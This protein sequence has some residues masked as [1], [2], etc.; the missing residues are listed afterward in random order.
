MYVGHY[1]IFW[2]LIGKFAVAYFSPASIVASGGI[3]AEPFVARENAST[4]IVY[5]CAAFLWLALFWNLGFHQWPWQ[6]TNPS[7]RLG[8]KFITILLFSTIVYIFL[9]HP[10]VCNLFYPAQDKAG[11]AP[12]WEG[13]A[14]TGSAFFS[15]GLVLCS[16]VWIVFS[17]LLWEG[18]PWKK[19]EKNGEATFQKGIVTFFGTLILGFLLLYILLR[20]FTVIW[21]VPFVGGQ[22]TDGP[23]WRLIHG[24]EVAGFF[25]LAAFIL[26][27][28]FNNFPRLPNLWARA[29]IR[30]LLAIAGG[31]LIYW[32]YFSP[33]A[34]FFLAKVQGFAQ[35]GD[36]PLVWVLLFLSIILVHTEFF[37]GW[38]LTQKK[39]EA[40]G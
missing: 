4:A 12:W 32:F 19:L 40:G 26:N 17:D 35:P 31:M 14:G 9:F 38:P 37:N 8:S 39:E 6:K 16:L 34:T 27:K 24:A 29:A 7:T 33:L 5:F 15:L 2:N 21:D 18:Y 25:I 22:Y 1:L 28:Y 13:F 20:I 23:D 11:V 30:S 3:G 36:T 10:H